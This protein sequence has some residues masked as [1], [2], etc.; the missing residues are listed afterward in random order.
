[1]DFA[2]Y[3]KI[4]LT[5]TLVGM[6]ATGLVIFSFLVSSDQYEE[7]L[8][9]KKCTDADSVV[10]TRFNYEKELDV[11][12]KLCEARIAYNTE[13]LH[14]YF[15]KGISPEKAVLGVSASRQTNPTLQRFVQS[16]IELAQ[17]QTYSEQVKAESNKCDYTHDFEICLCEGIQQPAEFVSS[18]D[19]KELIKQVL[20][21]AF[22]PGAMDSFDKGD[23]GFGSYIFVSSHT[24]ASQEELRKDAEKLKENNEEIYVGIDGEGG[25]VQR[26]PGIN[27]PSL[28]S[29]KNLSSEDFCKAIR[30]D[31]KLFNSL[32]INW[33][34]APVLDVAEDSSYWIYPR[35]IDTDSDKVVGIGAEYIQ[36]LQSEDVLATA[37]HYPGHGGTSADSH[38]VIPEVNK[39][40]S[41]WDNFDRIPFDKAIEN[42][43]EFVMMGH[44]KFP[45]IKNEIASL[46]KYWMEDVLRE[47]MNFKGLIVTDDLNMLQPKTTQ[48]CAQ[49]IATAINNG[50]DLALFVADPICDPGKIVTI[51]DEQSL[52]KIDTLLQRAENV[53]SSKKKAF[54]LPQ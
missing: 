51:I 16:E 46:S 11:L 21:P 9:L 52:I 47:E 23:Q 44:L 19:D 31:A 39:T 43:V 22:S 54:C 38:K 13:K 7:Y 10:L 49:N 40:K 14:T 24:Y 4:S 45:K 8:A 25:I 3:I 15:N 42:E 30:S 36:C 33:N 35:V 27:I 20:T 32:G 12:T 18:Y 6:I 17:I 29:R 50:A 1:M 28:S 2:K 48:E 26:V 37:K 53:Y 41:E 34:L 5:S